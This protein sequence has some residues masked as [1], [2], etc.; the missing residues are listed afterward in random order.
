MSPGTA[1]LIRIFSA[2]LVLLASSL[3]AASVDP[4]K[5][6]ACTDLQGPSNFDYV[7]LASIADSPHLLAMAGY[8]PT[9]A[10]RSEL[11]PHPAAH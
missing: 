11:K 7:V 8:R 1:S 3:V 2:I 4:S 9:A 5:V 10:K 6:R